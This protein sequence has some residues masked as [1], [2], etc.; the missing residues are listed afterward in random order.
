MI[1]LRKG[2]PFILL[3]LLALAGCGSTTS[4]STIS[5][6]SATATAC[7]QATR[8]ASASAFKTA[9]GTLNTINGQTLTMT[10]QRGSAVTVT[11]TSSTS[12]TQER[13]VPATTLQEGAS[14]R[15]VVNSSGS[16]YSAISITEVSGTKSSPFSGNGSFAGGRNSSC[17]QSGRTG[18][19]SAGANANGFRGL[20][21][22]VGQLNG[23]T[24]T[25][26]DAAGS[27]Y[28][29]TITTQTQIVQTQ[30]ATAAALK[31]GQPLTVIGKANGQ[32][33]ITANSVAILLS[34]PTPKA[35][36]TPAQ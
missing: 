19:G 13:A 1:N 23:N 27:A 21:G 14:V 5:G 12:F 8:P 30:S 18:K 9:T 33:A 25:I 10:N 24:L 26:T 29:V 31:V 3:C 17:L 7:A 34:L 32:S 20:V 22:T 11:Y 36:P 2:F 35:T 4:A 6:A 28:T 15:V 16:T